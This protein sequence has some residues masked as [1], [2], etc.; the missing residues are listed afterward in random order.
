M[1][2]ADDLAVDHPHDAVGG[3]A[4][5][6]VVGHDQERQASLSI[7]SP[8]QPHDLGGVLAVEITRRLVRPDDGRIV[9]ERRA[10][11]ARWR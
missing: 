5:G 11:V 10:I 3:A 6:D 1:L 9:D 4:H 7:E 8:H 2:F